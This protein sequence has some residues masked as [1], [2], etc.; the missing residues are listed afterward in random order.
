MTTISNGNGADPIAAAL[1]D[2]DTDGSDVDATDE[3]LADDTSVAPNDEVGDTGV[4]DAIDEPGDTD[5]ADELDANQVDDTDVADEL[6]VNQVDDNEVDDN[7]VDDN[8][9]D[10]NEVDDN[11]VDDNEVDDNEVD[12]NELAGD[13]ATG[14]EATDGGDPGE[15]DQEAGPPDPPVA[16]EPPAMASTDEWTTAQLTA[17]LFRA[18]VVA[19]VLSLVGFGLGFLRGP[20]QVA[21]AEFVYTLD[22]SVPDSFL[23]EDRRLLT[24]VATFTSDAVLGPV[25]RQFELDVEELRAAIDI[26][27]VDLSEVLR[28]E[29]T[30]TDPGRALAINRAVLDQF[31]VVVSAATPAGDSRELVQSRDELLAE[32]ELADERLLAL[33][34]AA[35][36]DAVL[37]IRQEGIQRRVDLARDRIAGI[38]GLLDDALAT[39]PAGARAAN[40]AAELDGATTE[41]TTLEDQL[42]AVAAERAELTTATTAEPALLREVERLEARLTTVDEELAQRELGP[43]VA[44]PIRELSEPTVVEQSAVR[45]GLQGAAIAA[46]IGLPLAAWVAYRTRRRQLWIAS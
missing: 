16:P 22:G 46:L 44:S 37:G 20:S 35:Q 4:D 24:Q 25:A 19:L 34:A 3:E 18:G 36:R 31:L 14:D 15:T 32:L 12:D 26:Q 11:E 5:V 8:E 40:L 39:A 13:E 10:D 30:D 45:A 38:Q 33:D 42:A 23:R 17:V 9:V 2:G 21:R 28:L 1:D 27:T 41:L 7:E 43:L 29:V 6:D